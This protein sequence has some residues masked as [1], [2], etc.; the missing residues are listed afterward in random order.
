MTVSDYQTKAASFSSYAHTS[1]PEKALR[2]YYSTITPEAMF[3]PSSEAK[4][5]E[6]WNQFVGSIWANVFQ[7]GGVQS[8]SSLLEVAPGEKSKIG[9]GLKQLCP[10]F[11]GRLT[12][13]EP[14]GDALKK[15]TALYGELHPDAR[16]IPLQTTLDGFIQN[17][18][19]REESGKI[20]AI[21]ANHGIDD[22]IVGKS[23]VE[24]ERNALF[25]NHYD[26]SEAG[27]TAAS[28]DR[29]IANP[30]LLKRIKID[31]VR[32]WVEAT[33]LTSPR[34]LALSAYRSHFF[35]EHSQQFPPLV[36]ADYLALETLT[37]IRYTLANKGYRSYRIEPD[38]LLGSAQDWVVMTN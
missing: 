23:M 30:N 35:E 38:K 15:I 31:V 7:V 27:R 5:T 2:K 4:A 9:I 11:T 34:L 16:L 8:D 12:V 36:E 13:I 20:A 29:L 22:M 10:H 6:E 26:D 24:I 33:Q 1:Y 18:D 14:E 32:E 25:H 37:D 3:T 19:A 21:A 17:T 28:W